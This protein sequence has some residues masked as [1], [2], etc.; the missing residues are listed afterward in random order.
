MFV[1]LTYLLTYYDNV[2]YVGLPWA[3]NHKNKPT[4][5]QVACPIYT[6]ISN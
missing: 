2:R 4:H 5:R 1:L 6:F 3:E